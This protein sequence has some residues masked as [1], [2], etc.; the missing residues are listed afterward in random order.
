MSEIDFGGCFGEDGHTATGV[1]VAL[2]EVLELGCGTATET[3]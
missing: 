3:E 1:F 2:F